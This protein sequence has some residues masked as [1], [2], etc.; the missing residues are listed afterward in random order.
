MFK[1]TEGHQ[2]IL[3]NIRHY[4]GVWS[5]NH[6]Y[7]SSGKNVS[8]TKQAIDL[9]VQSYLDHSSI[10]CIKTASKNQIPSITSSSNACG[11]NPEEIFEYLRALDK[12]KSVGF[13][14]DFSWTC[15]NSSKMFCVSLCQMQ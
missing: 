14:Y 9:I 11:I 8:D 4:W 5:H 1:N 6:T 7:C 2:G 13:R 12:K 15:K 3:K 10:N